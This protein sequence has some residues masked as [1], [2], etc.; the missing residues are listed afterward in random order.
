MP[1]PAS[2]RY[3]PALERKNVRLCSERRRRCQSA[4]A[5]ACSANIPESPA[6][7]RSSSGSLDAPAEPLH[8]LGVTLPSRHLLAL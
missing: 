4:T 5:I 3:E 2:T 7:R 6:F 8:D 1:S